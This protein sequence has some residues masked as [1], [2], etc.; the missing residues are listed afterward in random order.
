[1]ARLKTRQARPG[2]D[3]DLDPPV[4]S[5]IV[6]TKGRP[7][8]LEGCLAAL[9]GADYP[10]ERFEVV[11]VNDGGGAEVER[12]VER[13]ADTVS[14]R[15]TTSA[16]TGPSAARN[17]GAW[18]AE[19]RHLAFTDDDC[20][21]AP[22]WLAALER[23]LGQDPGAAV[24]GVMINAVK[25]NPAAVASQAVVDSLLEQFNRG[26]AAP[27]FFASSNLAFPAE[28]FRAVGGFDED[29]RYAEDRELCRRWI[30]SGNRLVHAPDALVYHMRTL[31]LREF[32]GQHHGYGRGAW[33]F[34][35]AA[36]DERWRSSGVLRALARRALRPEP[37]AKRIAT[38]GYV[39][40]SQVATA[41]GFAREAAVHRLA[42]LRRGASGR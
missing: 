13:L 38:A 11:V 6:P 8:Y 23:A 17:A 3:R 19:G 35:H 21:P 20:E 39:A 18:A 15:L 26:P 14:V 36:P 30:R 7:R 41:S 22:G 24:G 4:L 29:F 31:T 42:R 1:M 32:V 2:A 25:R 33:A 34:Q 28:P 12:V 5:V 37:G 40:L 27:R 9:A 16:R 10:R